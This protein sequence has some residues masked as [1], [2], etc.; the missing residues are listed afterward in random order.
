MELP[1]VE[2]GAK[3]DEALTRTG[4]PMYALAGVVGCTNSAPRTQNRK[5]MIENRK[6]NCYNRYTNHIGGVLM[7]KYLRRPVPVLW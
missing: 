1:G 2:P 5:E 7:L 6:A 3:G 4:C